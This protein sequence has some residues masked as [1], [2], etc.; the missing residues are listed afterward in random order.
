MLLEDDEAGVED[1]VELEL[2]L[3]PQSAPVTAGTC[4]A[5]P[6]LVPWKPNSADWPGCKLPFQ[7]ALLALYGLLPLTLAFQLLVTRLSPEYCQLTFQ[8]FTAA[9]V[10]LVTL[11]DAVKPL[12][13]WLVTVYWQAA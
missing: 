1:G 13:H 12:F 4:G 2:T 10:L 9:L 3:P 8:P 6:P 11:T 5:A 7:L